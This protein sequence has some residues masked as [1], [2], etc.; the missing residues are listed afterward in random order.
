MISF[1]CDFGYTMVGSPS[2]QC[3]ANSEWNPPVP[4]CVKS[5]YLIFLKPLMT[6]VLNI[7]DV[8][9]KVG[10]PGSGESYINIFPSLF[11]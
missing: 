9:F 3:D 10:H 11:G 1:K 8:N 2:V 4:R 7:K 6:S 5:K